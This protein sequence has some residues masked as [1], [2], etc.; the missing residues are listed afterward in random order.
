MYIWKI[1]CIL[2]TKY[3]EVYHCLT[4]KNCV[5]YH[6]LKVINA[7]IFCFFSP[8]LHG[9]AH[10]ICSNDDFFIG[11]AIFTEIFTDLLGIS[12]FRYVPLK[13]CR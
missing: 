9:K 1:I 7:F 10:K 4:S 2:L 6:G 5:F 13:N 3:F 11:N 8:G 12:F